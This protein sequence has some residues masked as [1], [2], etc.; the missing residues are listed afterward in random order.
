MI[1]RIGPNIDRIR[2][3]AEKAEQVIDRVGPMLTQTFTKLGPV[4]DDAGKAV[5]TAN[6]ILQEARPRVMEIADEGAGFDFAYYRD[7]PAGLRISPSL[8][9][10]VLPACA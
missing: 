4:I 10:S 8:R 1:E 7:A 6:Q 9:S 5:A 2:P 3:V